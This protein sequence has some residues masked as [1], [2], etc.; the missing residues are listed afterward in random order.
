MQTA[1]AGMGSRTR[2]GAQRQFAIRSQPKHSNATITLKFIGTGLHLDSYA[3]D[4]HLSDVVV[5]QQHC[6]GNT[7]PLY[8]GKVKPKGLHIKFL[9][10]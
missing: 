7:L 8:K 9:S 2:R 1:P 6:G 4:S 3:M 10:P 5:V